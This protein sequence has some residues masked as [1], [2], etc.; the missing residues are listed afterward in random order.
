MLQ[1]GIFY[2]ADFAPAD[3]GQLNTALVEGENAE[4]C[5]TVCFDFI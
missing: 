4:K 1:W 5:I 3:L 2:C